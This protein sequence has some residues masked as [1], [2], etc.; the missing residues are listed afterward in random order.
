MRFSF[1]VLALV[2]ISFIQADE[3]SSHH[4]NPDG[5]HKMPGQPTLQPILLV[6]AA[7]PLSLVFSD[8]PED[9]KPEVVLHRVTATRRIPLVVEAAEIRDGTWS[10][11]WTPPAARGPVR[12]EVRFEGKPLRAVWIESRDPEWIV[13]ALEGLGTQYH[14]ESR[15]LSARERE[16]LSARGLRV[17]EV[18]TIREGDPS[19]IEMVPRQGH[20]ARRRVFWSIDHPS[21]VVWSPGPAS[22][23]IQLHAPRWWIDPEALATDHGLIRIIDLFSE[24]PPKD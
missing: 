22:G 10:W 19:V 16:A 20:T 21:L 18:S 11:Q 7:K 15:G 8:M 13:S 2:N 9:W 1:L 5:S 6:I 14:W 24:P 23:D 3:S 17:R 12:Y 4:L